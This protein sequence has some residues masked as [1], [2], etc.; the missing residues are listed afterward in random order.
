[1]VKIS[2]VVPVYNL[3][4]RLAPLMESLKRQDLPAD[5]FEVIFV[6]DGSTDAT[7]EEISANMACNW[8]LLRQENQKQGA[9]RNNGLREALGEYVWFVDGDDAIE[10]N[11][12]KKIYECARDNDVD[13]LMFGLR[14]YCNGERA[15]DLVAPSD[16]IGEVYGGIQYLN[17]R[18]LTLCSVYVYRRQF[19]IQNNLFYIPDTYYEDSEFVPRV[20]CFA[21]RVMNMDGAPYIYLQREDSTST[22]VSFER[23]A[24][25]LKIS[26]AL[27]DDALQ[28]SP[29]ARSSLYY[30]ASMIFNT[31]FAMYR[32]FPG[33]SGVKMGADVKGRVIKAMLLSKR[34]KY[35]LEG[36]VL[37]LAWRF[38]FK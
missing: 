13:V 34:L 37:L 27:C 31:M 8:R 29:Q 11:C 30:Y 35:I 19:L 22:G 14:R 10:E 23:M 38:I 26:L 12:L 24:S 3:E 4:G 28:F 18:V 5:E 1:M 20:C 25:A 6:D 36:C 33:D 2:I 21:G 7:A 15:C 32:R 9:A 16:C 17:K